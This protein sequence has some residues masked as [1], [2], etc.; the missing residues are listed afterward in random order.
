MMG[1]MFLALFILAGTVWLLVRPWAPAG[2]GRG[3]GRCRREK[4]R[5]DAQNNT[6]RVTH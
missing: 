2:E 6:N 4:D 1:L 5:N 3:N